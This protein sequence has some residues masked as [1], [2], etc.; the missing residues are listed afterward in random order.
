MDEV[1]SA[2]Q[3]RAKLQKNHVQHIRV[4]LDLTNTFLE[5]AKVEAEQGEEE[6]AQASLFHAHQAV[7]IARQGLAHIESAEQ[8]ATLEADVV[9]AEA[10]VRAFC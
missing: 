8:R 9:R 2:E 6:A 4:Q 1:L 7:G 5:I 3:L 10:A